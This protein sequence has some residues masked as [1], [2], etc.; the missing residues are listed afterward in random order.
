MPTEP[1]TVGQQGA[2]LVAAY[3]RYDKKYRGFDAAIEA[4]ETRYHKRLDALRAAKDAEVETLTAGKKKLKCPNW[5]NALIRPFMDGVAEQTGWEYEISGPYG[6][7][8]NVPVFF[9]RGSDHSTDNLTGYL[10]FTCGSVFDDG[11]V[12]LRDYLTDTGQFRPGSIGYMN[13]LN[14]PTIEVPADATVDWFLEQIEE[15]RRREESKDKAIA[16]VG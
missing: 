4:A 8:G 6:L 16:K 10:Q 13:E 3:K 5:I 7:G 12:Y 9:Y 15:F 2:K 1:L 11:K 14:H